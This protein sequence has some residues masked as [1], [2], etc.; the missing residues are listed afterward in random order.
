MKK[1]FTKI[2]SMLLACALTIPAITGTADVQAAKVPK[3]NKTKITKLAVGKTT[4]IRINAN[5]VKKNVKIIKKSKKNAS[6]KGISEG[7]ATI[8]A[9]VKYRATAKSKVK[10]KGLKCTV[11]VVNAN[12]AATAAAQTTQPAN[13]PAASAATSSQGRD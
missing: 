8:T 2:T 6:I 11:K 4:T 9:K 5:G 10:T 12:T 13:S 7:K 3:L 1:K